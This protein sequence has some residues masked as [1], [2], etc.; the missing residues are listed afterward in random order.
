MERGKKFEKKFRTKIFEQKHFDSRRK[1]HFRTQLIFV[2]FVRVKSF[3][4][5]STSYVHVGRRRRRCCCRRRRCRRR[6]RRRRFV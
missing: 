4:Y 2:G 1:D 6:R 3:G 5:F